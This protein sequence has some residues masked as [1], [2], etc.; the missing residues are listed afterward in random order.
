MLGCEISEI[1][2]SVDL[3][4]RGGW[5]G[6]SDVIPAHPPPATVFRRHCLK[7]LSLTPTLSPTHSHPL[8]PPLLFPMWCASPRRGVAASWTREGRVSAAPQRAAVVSAAWLVAAT[9]RLGFAKTP[10]TW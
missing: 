3:S 8:T 7:G 4:T 10:H 5:G 1:V 9:W 6:C 2:G